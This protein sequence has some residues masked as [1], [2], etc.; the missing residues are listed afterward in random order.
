MGLEKI[1][2]SHLSVR[3]FENRAAAFRHRPMVFRV[4]VELTNDGVFKTPA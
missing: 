3:S 2:F 4:R 1:E